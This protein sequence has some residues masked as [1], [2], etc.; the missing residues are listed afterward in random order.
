MYTRILKHLL[1]WLSRR[2][3]ET[4]KASKKKQAAMTTATNKHVR[5]FVD[6]SASAIAHK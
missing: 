5:L 3:N 2:Q 6:N 1:P 4:A